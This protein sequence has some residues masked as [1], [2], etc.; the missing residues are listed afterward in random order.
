MKTVKLSE[1]IFSISRLLGKGKSGYSYL[2]E[3]GE[4]K[5]VLKRIH[6]E[7]CEYYKFGDKLDSEL[8]AYARLAGFI[9]VPRLVEYNT[10][11][12]YLVKEYIPGVPVSE[13]AAQGKVPA[14]AFR[15]IFSW[16][17]KLYGCGINIDYFP[18][19]FIWT[20][21]Q[22]VYVDYEL[23]TYLEEWNFENWGIYYWLNAAG[24]R[25]LLATGDY[26]A[27]NVAKNSGKPITEPFK[28]LAAELAAR[29]NKVD[30]PGGTPC[31]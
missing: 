5:Y 27:I 30:K 18:A 17:R 7:P 1:G 16:C 24:M 3:N 28:A 14:E 31:P 2:I 22:L 26:R 6:D 8:K 21:E 19:N 10:A 9:P 20:G 4:T 11:E 29:Y 25:T 13:L 12:K 23:N 15:E